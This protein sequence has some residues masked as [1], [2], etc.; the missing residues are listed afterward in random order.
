MEGWGGGPCRTTFIIQWNQG[1]KHLGM[2]CGSQWIVQS[3]GQGV[4]MQWCLQYR[5]K[6]FLG[7]V[8]STEEFPW[9]SSKKINDL[10]VPSCCNSHC[11]NLLYRAFY[12]QV[13]LGLTFLKQS[14][15]F[16]D[17]PRLQH[18]NVTLWVPATSH[19]QLQPTD[20]RWFNLSKKKYNST[21]D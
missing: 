3:A 2:K 19:L 14:N 17:C 21:L 5:C 12:Y 20:L 4:H 16:N 11:H 9:F 8:E 6:W 10:F 18:Q 13:K 15:T 7:F 1:M